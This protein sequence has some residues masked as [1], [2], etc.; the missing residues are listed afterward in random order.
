MHYMITNRISCC[1]VYQTQNYV[2][3]SQD[4]QVLSLPIRRVSVDSKTSQNST[5]RIYDPK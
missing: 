5:K 2:Y 1:P 4:V 3:G